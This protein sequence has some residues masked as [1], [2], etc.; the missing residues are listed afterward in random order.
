MLKRD[1]MRVEHLRNDLGRHLQLRTDQ[2]S[3]E[4]NACLIQLIMCGS[5]RFLNSG[6]I[7]SKSISS[8]SFLFILSC[9]F[10]VGPPHPSCDAIAQELKS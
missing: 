6:S 10:L 5:I 4:P 3:S 2:A 8:S 9:P 1:E 7:K